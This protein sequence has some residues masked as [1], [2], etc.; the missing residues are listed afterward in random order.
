M[1]N[2]NSD[3]LYHGT[4][5]SFIKQE[6]VAYIVTEI[7]CTILTIIGNAIVLLVFWNDQQKNESQKII[8]KY[9]VSMAL[10][11]LLMGIIGIPTSI[12]VSVGLPHHRFWCL[13][14]I[15]LQMSFAMISVLALVAASTAKYL[16]VAYPIWFSTKFN[17]LWATCMLPYM[18]FKKLVIIRKNY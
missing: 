6:D 14:F 13:A 5:R 11:D 7:V 2:I 3:S 1:E 17:E 12:Y 10:A 18:F 9:V 16:S 15:S 4:D 8:H